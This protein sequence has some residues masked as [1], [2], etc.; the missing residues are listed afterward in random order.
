VESFIAV[1]TESAGELTG[2]A[3]ARLQHGEFG[4]DL[5]I[6]LLD[7]IGVDPESRHEGQGAMLLEGILMHMKKRDIGELRTQVDWA[8]QE[9]VKF[10][11]A[12]G[13]DL[14]PFQVLERATTRNV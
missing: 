10:F 12:Q 14:A 9:L 6:A 13:F 2:Y 4:G 3:I 11:A 8:Q 7:V 5:P 1:A